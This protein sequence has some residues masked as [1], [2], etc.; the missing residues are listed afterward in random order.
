MS[1]KILK[2]ILYLTGNQCKFIKTYGTFLPIGIL[3]T[4]REFT[5]EHLFIPIE[6]THHYNDCSIRGIECNFSINNC[7][8]TPLIVPLYAKCLIECLFFTYDCRKMLMIFFW[9]Y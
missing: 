3:T 5:N 2:L 6:H 9:C 1:N 7:L 4:C 8:L